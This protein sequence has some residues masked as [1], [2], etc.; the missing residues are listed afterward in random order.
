MTAGWR[1]A[2]SPET[3]SREPYPK[4]WIALS[5]ARL[6]ELLAKERQRQQAGEGLYAGLTTRCPFISSLVSDHLPSQ[7]TSTRK[8]L[9]SASTPLACSVNLIRIGSSKPTGAWPQTMGDS[10]SC[11][12]DATCSGCFRT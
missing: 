8:T 5:I 4:T 12:F 11:G 6:P 7:E 2:L 3:A 1:I 9:L 10:R